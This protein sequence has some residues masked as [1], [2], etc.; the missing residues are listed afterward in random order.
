MTTKCEGE[1]E[2]R[3]EET[4]LEARLDGNSMAKDGNGS[5]LVTNFC[6]SFALDR[7]IEARNLEKLPDRRV[8]PIHFF[9]IYLFIPIRSRKEGM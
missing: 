4:Y 2:L 6:I 8:R 9:F 3:T 1:K 5:S 7:R